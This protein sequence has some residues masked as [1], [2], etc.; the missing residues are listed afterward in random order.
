M[1][2]ENPYF[3]NNEPKN[4]ESDAA[5]RLSDLA[6]NG[7]FEP[8]PNPKLAAVGIEVLHLTPE[9]IPANL[10]ALVPEGYQSYYFGI[11]RAQ[12]IP[13]HLH[14]EDGEIYLLLEEGENPINVTVVEQDGES[15]TDSLQ[16]ANDHSVAMPDQSHFIDQREN[17][18]TIFSIKFKPDVAETATT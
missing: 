10:K 1:S 13:Q 7:K 17:K 4:L 16:K 11:V 18:F 3:Y 5:S 12:E 15:R 9:Q 8:H 14:T 6:E 2:P